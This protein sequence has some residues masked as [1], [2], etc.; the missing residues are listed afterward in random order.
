MRY[1]IIFLFILL[2]SCESFNQDRMENANNYFENGEY[3]NAKNELS[4]IP[5]S[6][7][8]YN[9][10]MVLLQ[11][12]DSVQATFKREQKKKYDSHSSK[13]TIPSPSSKYSESTVSTSKSR[14]ERWLSLGYI[15]I[16][17][18]EEIFISSEL[19]SSVDIDGK[20]EVV[21]TLLVYTEV[22]KNRG[23][24]N[25]VD[26]FDKQTGKEIASWSDFSDLEIK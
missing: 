5:E 8:Y 15:K 11:V 16:K 20:R 26:F 7:D 17:S 22:F 1:I 6:S 9:E 25:S 19:W 14:V 21:S 23:A 13:K 3:Q 10:A 12:V 18:D 24:F 4:K 2:V